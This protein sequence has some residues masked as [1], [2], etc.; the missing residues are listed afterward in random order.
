MPKKSRR[1]KKR[2]PRA[3]KPQQAAPVQ[4]TH[5]T[6]QAV[7]DTRPTTQEAPVQSYGSQQHVITELRQIGILAAGILLTLVVLSFVLG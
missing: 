6:P 5:S 2:Q 4:Y 1:T 7:Q 3:A